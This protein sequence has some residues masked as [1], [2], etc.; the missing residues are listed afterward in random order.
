MTLDGSIIGKIEKARETIQE[1][2]R[3]IDSRTFEDS[4]GQK[5]WVFPGIS[6]PDYLE[7]KNGQLS[8]ILPGINYIQPYSKEQINDVNKTSRVLQTA[9][10]TPL[11]KFGE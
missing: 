6:H 11:M 5:A 1:T 3:S 10:E 8:I 7:E 4:L 9:L 2:V